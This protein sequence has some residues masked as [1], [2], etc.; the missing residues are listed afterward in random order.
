MWNLNYDT[1]EFIYETETD[2]QKQ[3]TDLWL[4]RGRWV[5]EGWVGSWGQQIQT[6]I[7]RLDKQQGPTIQH[8][9]LYSVSVNNGKEYRKECIYICK[10]ESLCCTAEI[11]TT[12]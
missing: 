4:P 9:E 6:S 7:Y 11:D 12:L 5:R 8:R 2:S 10:I 3:R 1:N